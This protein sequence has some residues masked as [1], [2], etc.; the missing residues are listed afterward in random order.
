MQPPCEVPCEGDGSDAVYGYG[1]ANA[2]FHLIGDCP[3]V[4][5][6]EGSGI[7]FT[8]SEAGE[9]LLSVFADV[10]LVDPD[11]ES[12]P[13]VSDLFCS[14]L[15]MCCL[16]EG[17]RPSERQYARLEP[18]FDAELRAISAHVLLPVGER[19]TRRVFESYTARP[20]GEALDMEELHASELRGSGFLV[21]PIAD[22]TDWG[23]NEREQLLSRM[24]SIL[25]S[26]YRQAS[27][28]GRFVATQDQYIVR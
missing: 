27:E 22:P 26:D 19:A 20:V 2:D 10:D 24:R 5:G 14:Y 13:R 12:D 3:A 7:P 9:Q 28:L 15:H 16:P 23:G 6:G 18:F 8:G 4:H 1:D 25:A 17:D 21:V 11:A